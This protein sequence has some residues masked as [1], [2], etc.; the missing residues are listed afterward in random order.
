MGGLTITRKIGED[1]LIGDD[2]VVRVIEIRSGQAKLW[3]DAPREIP[4]DRREIRER[5]DRGEPAPPR[6]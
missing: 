1:V 6:A 4:I 5:K 2:V 3:I